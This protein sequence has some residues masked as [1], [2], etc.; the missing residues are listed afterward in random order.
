MGETGDPEPSRSRLGAVS[1]LP[2]KVAFPAGGIQKP[3]EKPLEASRGRSWPRVLA[4]PLTQRLPAVKDD[5]LASLAAPCGHGKRT[6]SIRLPG[7]PHGASPLPANL[8]DT[9]LNAWPGG[10]REAM[11]SGDPRLRGVQAC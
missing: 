10:M 5:L 9:P 4:D 7:R 3:L 8:P 2:A 11:K 1:E 6:S